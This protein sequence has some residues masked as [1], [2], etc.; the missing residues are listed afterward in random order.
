MKTL[1]NFHEKFTEDC[2][3]A[4]SE[5]K[6]SAIDVYADAANNAKQNITQFYHTCDYYL[7]EP[8]LSLKR[9]DNSLSEMQS[10]LENA[11][12]KFTE[13]FHQNRIGQLIE[14]E[15]LALI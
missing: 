6:S 4:F 15:S 13:L 1:E 10:T 11:R 12:Q 3:S 5:A 2:S 14:S 8:V 9:L 7:Q